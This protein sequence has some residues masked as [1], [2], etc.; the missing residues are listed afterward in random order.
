MDFSSTVKG[1]S[2]EGFYPAG[3]DME[4]IDKCCSNAPESIYDRQDFWNKDFNLV[5]CEDV[6]EF[7]ALMGHEIAFKIKEARDGVKPPRYK[8]L[9]NSI[10]DAPPLS[11]AKASS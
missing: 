11:L 1:S 5:G 10:L 6:S 9:F 8:A 4:K 3:W 2:L 7:D